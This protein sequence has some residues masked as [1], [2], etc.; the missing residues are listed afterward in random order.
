MQRIAH[1]I[2]DANGVKFCNKQGAQSRSVSTFGPYDKCE[3][4]EIDDLALFY[5]LNMASANARRRQRRAPRRAPTSAATSP[6]AR[7]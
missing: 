6:T 4:F 2:H 3:L 1:L 5:I 7:S